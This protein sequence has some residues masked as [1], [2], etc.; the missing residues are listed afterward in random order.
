MPDDHQF[1]WGFQFYVAYFYKFLF[2]ILPKLSLDFL[3]KVQIRSEEGLSEKKTVR[4][5]E[6][7]L[8]GWLL[9]PLS[10]GKGVLSEEEAKQRREFLVK[11]SGQ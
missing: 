6:S 9:P 11:A 3:I 4:Q 8:R 5:H 10:L 1:S 7:H 2:H